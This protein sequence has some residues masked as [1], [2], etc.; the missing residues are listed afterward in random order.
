MPITKAG[1]ASFFDEFMFLVL[2]SQYLRGHFDLV[3]QTTHLFPRL[4][5]DARVRALFLDNG[6]KKVFESCLTE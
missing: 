1:R 5:V 2:A 6:G 4:R 3:Q